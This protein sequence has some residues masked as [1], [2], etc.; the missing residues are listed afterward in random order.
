MT[1]PEARHAS[2][3]EQPQA[4]PL[5]RRET[6][7]D[8]LPGIC[9][10]RVAGFKSI[11]DER[12]IEIRP[13]TILAGA[14]GSGK[15]SMM[16]PLLLLKQTLQASYD[17]GPLLLDGPHVTFTSFAQLLSR[18]GAE[19]SER[20]FSVGLAGEAGQLL[21]TTYVQRSNHAITI[22]KMVQVHGS[23]T[24]ELRLG[25]THD[26]V[27]RQLPKPVRKLALALSTRGKASRVELRWSV[28]RSRCFL[29]V[30][31]TPQGEPESRLGETS[32]P[33]TSPA[34]VFELYLRDL[35]H[36][37]ALRGTP[38]RSY[39]ISATSGE[40]Q[41]TFDNYAASIIAW[42]WDN[43][44]SEKLEAL[45]QDLRHLGLA[46]GVEPRRVADTRVELRVGSPAHRGRGIGQLKV[47]IADVGFGVSQALPVLVALRVA[48]KG[49]LVYLEQPEIHLHPY[50]QVRLAD[51]LID[52]ANRGVR[53]VAET[54]S[55]LLLLGIQ[56]RVAQGMI[57]PGNTKLHWFSLGRDGTTN[58][59]SADFDE[60]GRYGEWPEDFGR[61]ELEASREY[62]DAV[63]QRLQETQGDSGGPEAFSH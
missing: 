46:S 61:I 5:G 27:E 60:L 59:A 63:A 38:E 42:W 41:G 15:S 23:H 4:P 53:V 2:A 50:A 24:T 32:I 12:A 40:F 25:M 45:N 8:R 14:N 11:T 20:A 37:P 39:R 36:L 35:I 58:I 54:H 16:Q 17:P 57:P 33:L 28:V 34:G 43:R 52:A 6:T 1:E 10:A 3:G 49:Q 44:D 29:W 55:A 21:T 9:L 18:R 26:E 62:L 19:G 48:E 56:A 22:A 7:P 51:V 31:A 47:N 13:L 30:A